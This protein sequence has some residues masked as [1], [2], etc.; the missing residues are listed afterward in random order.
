MVM[1]EA[2]LSCAS[3]AAAGADAESTQAI[4]PAA[5]QHAQALDHIF[6]AL[7]S[8]DAENDG[9]LAKVEEAR[10]QQA[11]TS[12]TSVQVGVASG[13]ASSQRSHAPHT[14]YATSMRMK[15]AT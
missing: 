6:D 5:Q 4:S 1:N 2:T 11:A 9:V 15:A 8:Y 13:F 14:M 7:S 3:G 10:L 12:E